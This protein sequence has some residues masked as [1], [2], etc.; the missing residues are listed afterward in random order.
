[1]DV[2]AS[3]GHFSAKNGS[4]ALNVPAIRGESAAAQHDTV[5]LGIRPEDI[6]IAPDGEVSGEIFVVEPL[7]REDLIEVH[8]DEHRFILL[9]DTGVHKAGDTVSLKFDMEKAQ[10]FDT[11]SEKS[12]L[13]N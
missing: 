11:K 2:S 10:F 7:G 3:N 6:T 1:V 5:I 4:V 9:A 12:L 8:V 13:W